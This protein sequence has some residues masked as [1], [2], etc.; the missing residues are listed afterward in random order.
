MRKHQLQQGDS[1]HAVN[2]DVY[3]MDHA[4]AVWVVVADSGLVRCVTD[5]PIRPARAVWPTLVDLCTQPPQRQ[6]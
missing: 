5:P 3:G 2:I 6:G 1:I 4:R